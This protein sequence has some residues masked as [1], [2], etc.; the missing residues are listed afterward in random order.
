[1]VEYTGGYDWKDIYEE[2]YHEL[3]KKNNELAVKLGAA[4]SKQEELNEKLNHIE[5][6]KLWKL[7]APIRKAASLISNSDG[8]RSEKLAKVT[9]SMS[10]KKEKCNSVSGI[11]KDDVTDTKTDADQ[12]FNENDEKHADREQ[13]NDFQKAYFEDCYKQK[14][15]YIIWIEKNEEHYGSK[16]AYVIDNVSDSETTIIP[17]STNKDFAVLYLEDI[18]TTSTKLT[19]DLLIG[20]KFLLIVSKHGRFAEGAFDLIGEKM[21]SGKY[22]MLYGDEDYYLK[23]TGERMC[24]WFKPDWSP[25][26]LLSF[27]YFGSFVVFTTECINK[28][29]WYGSTDPLE[30]LYSLCIQ[31]G[32]RDIVSPD[33][34]SNNNSVAHISKVLFHKEYDFSGTTDEATLSLDNLIKSGDLRHGAE[35][36]Y[37]AMKKHILAEYGIKADVRSYGEPGI[38]VVDYMPVSIDEKNVT[39]GTAADLMVS[40]I[41]LSKDHPAVLKECLDSVCRKTDYSNYEIIVVDNGSNDEN[42]EKVEALKSDYAFKYIYDKK[43]FNFSEMCNEGVKNS[44]GELVFLMNDDV[45]VIEKDW[46]RLMAGQAMRPHVGAVGAKLYY[47][48]TGCMQHVGVTNL[49]AGP[50]HKLTSYPDSHDYYYGRN[51]LNY[52]MIGVTGAALMIKRSIYDDVGG[53]CTEFPVAYNDVDFCMNVYEKGFYNVQR[54]DVTFYHHES[55]SR[56]DDV[57]SAQKLTRLMNDMERLYARHPELK[58]RDPF[59]NVNLTGHIS[60]YICDVSPAYDDSERPNASVEKISAGNLAKTDRT[61]ILKFTVDHIRYSGLPC[62]NETVILIVDGWEYLP[63][64]DNSRFDKWILLSGTK[65]TM[66][67]AKP[68]TWYRRDVIDIL[69]NEKNVDLAGFIMRVSEDDLP[70]DDYRIGMMCIDTVDGRKITAWSERIL[71]SPHVENPDG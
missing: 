66:F 41:I 30:N 71:K 8:R 10:H 57:K 69:P 5:Q 24:P 55:L 9:A 3:Q 43:E 34:Y 6:N 16:P 64:E 54:N 44:S 32:L 2:R 33:N 60:D 29:T 36:K 28:L 45:E 13:Y 50:A 7:S 31:A 52:D 58:G 15:P 4:Q 37:A 23:S 46:M 67:R 61:D 20:K 39:A 68:D 1:M 49:T 70:P 12:C 48:S 25:D 18:G 22:C 19:A 63:G 14:N 42:R 38:S 11:S 65:G 47:A 56:G 27:M 53:L 59:Y 21:G 62:L 26:T 40:I 17:E 35:D 51:T